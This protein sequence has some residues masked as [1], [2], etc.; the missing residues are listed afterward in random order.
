MSS[1]GARIKVA[2]AKVGGLNKLA[3]L[4]DIPRRTLGDK[5]AG[6]TELEVSLLV[7]I[8][9]A[10]GASVEWL[11]TGNAKVAPPGDS[12][13]MADAMATMLKVVG[14]EVLRVFEKEGVR[15]PLYHYSAELAE[16]TAALLRRMDDPTDVAELESLMPW[17][18]GRIRKS[19]A[20]PGS[21]KR[22]AS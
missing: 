14:A 11:A 3:A 13:A 21:G 5:L 4:I 6:R 15:I 7:R 20:A 8:A 12:D 18:E 2:A 10:T 22:E 17:L 9:E 19:L 16:H 1:V